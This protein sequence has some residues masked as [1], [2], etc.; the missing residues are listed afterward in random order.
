MTR[1]LFN[2]LKISM[3]CSPVW[4]LALGTA[5]TP[6]HGS[7]RDLQTWGNA[8]RAG[9]G[10][11]VSGPNPRGSRWRQFDGSQAPEGTNA[12]NTGTT[13]RQMNAGREHRPKGI[14]S[15]TLRDAARFSAER[16]RSR[17]ILAAWA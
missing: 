3:A 14:T 4:R 11:R 10:S 13:P 1:S 12:S 16:N 8:S 15:L 9:P 2:C 7:L 17:L 6:S 5:P